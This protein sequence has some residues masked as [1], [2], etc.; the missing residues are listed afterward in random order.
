MITGSI[1]DDAPVASAVGGEG[2]VRPEP[3]LDIT[4][5]SIGARSVPRAAQE[6]RARRFEEEAPK[7][8]P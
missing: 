5:L 2:R 6:R 3:A 1:V 4:D 7:L 8:L